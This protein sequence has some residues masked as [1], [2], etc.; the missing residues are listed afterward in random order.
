[1]EDLTD[2]VMVLREEPATV[3]A[4]NLGE[5]L[6]ERSHSLS[7]QDLCDLLKTYMV[8]KQDMRVYEM[9]EQ[10]MILEV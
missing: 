9:L 7:E 5:I 4:L 6:C 2:L 10:R 8:D 1:M 3:S